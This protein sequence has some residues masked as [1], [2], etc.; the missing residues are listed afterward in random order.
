VRG[1]GT[2]R[3]FHSSTLLLQAVFF[4][5]SSYMIPSSMI[6]T[7]S[8][9]VCKHQAPTWGSYES[10]SR[11]PPKS[12]QH[13]RQCDRLFA[14]PSFHPG[15]GVRGIF[16]P[17]KALAESVAGTTSP[18]PANGV[19]ETRLQFLLRWRKAGSSPHHRA[20]QAAYQSC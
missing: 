18:R 7:V 8:F 5:H 13:Q 6:H 9:A 3:Q 15:Y 1:S 17:S 12:R 11:T 4:L 10:F 20:I 16:S 19:R 14:K 2:Q